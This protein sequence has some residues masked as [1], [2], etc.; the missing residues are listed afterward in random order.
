M[1]VHIFLGMDV[2]RPKASDFL[3]A[4]V[5]DDCELLSMDAGS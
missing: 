4:R 1:Y 2:Q 3:G 5:R